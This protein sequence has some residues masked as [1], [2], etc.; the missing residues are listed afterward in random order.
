[1]DTPNRAVVIACLTPL[2]QENKNKLLNIHL[3]DIT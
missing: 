1:M 2:V 3:S